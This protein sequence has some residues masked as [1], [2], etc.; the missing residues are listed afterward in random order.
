MCARH[1][2]APGSTKV[3][4][5]KERGGGWL[6]SSAVGKRGRKEEMHCKPR[7]F[8]SCATKKEE[9]NAPG[10]TP[11]PP[12][13][14]NPLSFSLRSNKDES[15]FS[16]Y[17]DGSLPR[18]Q[19]ALQRYPTRHNFFLAHWRIPLFCRLRGGE[20]LSTHHFICGTLAMPLCR[21]WRSLLFPCL[22][23]GYV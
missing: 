22:G 18:V 7:S 9:E 5:Q 14:K 10:G 19:E 17:F 6:P 16:T 15:R 13:S 3:V 8:C 20:Y 21:E 2:S 1:T 23:G 11:P 12:S 4:G